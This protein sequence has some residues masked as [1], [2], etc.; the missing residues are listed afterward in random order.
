MKFA[1]TDSYKKF[2]EYVGYDF[3]S[4][5]DENF[6][7][8]KVR[9]ICARNDEIYFQIILA[10]DDEFAFCLGDE[11]FFTVR[12]PIDIFRLKV[13]ADGDDIKTQTYPVDFIDDDDGL[14]YSDVLLGSR[15]VYRNKRQPGIVFVKI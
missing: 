8:K 15:N 2:R 7:N 10:S 5:F 14:R 4:S 3:L 11:P 1:I 6:G 9:L 13:S 12:G